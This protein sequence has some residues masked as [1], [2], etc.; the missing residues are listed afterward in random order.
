MA[1]NRRWESAWKPWVLTASTEDVESLTSHGLS[2]NDKTMKNKN[3]T[4]TP[5]DEI[6]L[7]TIATFENS[8]QSV[9]P[10]WFPGHSHVSL[11]TQPPGL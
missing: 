4:G 3:T 5:L 8:I 2:G 10:R 6:I 1:T 7:K 11:E 9:L